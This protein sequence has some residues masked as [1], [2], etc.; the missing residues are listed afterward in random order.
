[1]DAFDDIMTA[2][3]TP[4]AVVTT[5]TASDRAG[6]LIGFHAQASIQPPRLAIWLSKANH[7][8]RVGI[9]ASHLA[10]HFLAD[11]DHDLAEL[12]GTRTGD[13]I[14]KFAHC[15]WEPTEEGVP[16]LDRCGHRIVLR[17]HA[18]LDDGGDHV[19]VVG[20]PVTATSSGPF[21]PLRLAAVRDLVAGHPVDERPVPPTGRAA[22]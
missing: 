19:C 7:T 16:L 2:L 6:C 4:V 15:D 5:A 3:D 12:F 9:L 18:V 20:D 10:V 11:T 1:M 14:D 8:Y 13:D 17:K 22:D 21:T